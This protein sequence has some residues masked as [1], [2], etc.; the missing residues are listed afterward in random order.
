MKTPPFQHPFNDGALISRPWVT[1]FNDVFLRIDDGHGITS[2]RPVTN[3]RIGRRW[4]DDTLGY[5]IYLKSVNPVVWVDG[6]GVSR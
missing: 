4:F 1:W 5:P 6:A 2:D 3:L